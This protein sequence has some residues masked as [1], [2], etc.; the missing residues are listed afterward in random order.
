VLCPSCLS[1]ETEWAQAPG[2]GNIYYSVMRHVKEP[3]ILAYVTLDEGRTM[4][5]NI[6]DCEPDRLRIDQPVRVVFKSTPGGG[7]VVPMFRLAGST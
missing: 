6:I 4:M 7:M 5:T 2:K 1:S 3:Y